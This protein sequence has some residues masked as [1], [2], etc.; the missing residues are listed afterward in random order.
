MP[1]KGFKK[2]KIIDDWPKKLITDAIAYSKTHKWPQTFKW[3]TK[4]TK[5][6]KLPMYKSDS[7][8]RQAM[9]VY[10]G[11]RGT[12][13]NKKRSSQREDKLAPRTRQELDQIEQ[14]VKVAT[15]QKVLR[16]SFFIDRQ[17]FEV[18]WKLRKRF[19]KLLEDPSA[20]IPKLVSQMRR[21]LA[22]ADKAM[23][24]T[25]QVDVQINIVQVRQEARVEIFREILPILSKESKQRIDAHYSRIK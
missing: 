14:E 3:L 12:N 7:A 23:G 25:G 18:Y 10:G 9:Y 1:P 11:G 6:Q 5:A 13:T 2:K 15:E 22:D 19:D 21:L 17:R 20:D 24:R 4:K 16:S 8:L